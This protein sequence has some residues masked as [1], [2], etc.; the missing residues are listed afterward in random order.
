V[1][2]VTMDDRARLFLKTMDLTLIKYVVRRTRAQQL[3]RS[4]DW[5]ESA[6]RAYGVYTDNL[7]QVQRTADRT[8][9]GVIDSLG[10]YYR[11]TAVQISA[12]TYSSG[13]EDAVD[14]WLDEHDDP[15]AA[16]AFT[17]RGGVWTPFGQFVPYDEIQP[18][19]LVQVQEWRAREATLSPNDYRDNTTV[20]PLSGVRVDEAARTVELIPRTTS[21]QFAR[22]MAAIQELEM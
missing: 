17:I 8:S 16:G 11:R 19:D 10:G 20:F 15:I 13:V 4:G 21:D 5:G 6:Q 1:W 7:G 9:Q 18:G 14:L 22:Y 12:M 3:E 2:G